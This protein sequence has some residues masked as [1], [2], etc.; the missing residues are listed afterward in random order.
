MLKKKEIRF[1][2]GYLENVR[3]AKE[4]GKQVDTA[5]PTA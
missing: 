5:K 2:T 4:K 3:Q 1:K